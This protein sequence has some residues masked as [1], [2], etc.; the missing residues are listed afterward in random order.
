MINPQEALPA[1]LQLFKPAAIS[2]NTALFITVEQVII[3]N[4]FCC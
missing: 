4:I 2:L 3:C 1:G